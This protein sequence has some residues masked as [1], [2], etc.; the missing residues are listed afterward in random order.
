MI[1][2]LTTFLAAAALAVT[3]TLI[4]AR[5]ALAAPEDYHLSWFEAAEGDVTGTY[6]NV[7]G[8]I[9]ATDIGTDTLSEITN[10]SDLVIQPSCS[11]PLPPNATP[12]CFSAGD[13]SAEEWIPQGI[14]TTNDATGGSTSKILVSWYDGC[15]TGTQGTDWGRPN[16]GCQDGPNT[17]EAAD[18]GVRI[19]VYT[20][21]VG[22]RNVLLVEPFFNSSDNP[23]FH[24]THMH[25]GGIALYGNFLYVADT[26]YG[27]RVF[28][29]RKIFDLNEQLNPT[30]RPTN[31]SDKTKVG[32]HS[33]VWYSHG[34]RWVWPAVG[35]WRRDGTG[36]ATDCQGVGFPMKFSYLSV[37]RAARYLLA[38][39]YCPSD[40]SQPGRLAR[41]QLGS[42]AAT[43]PA[44]GIANGWAV[45][46]FNL[47]IDHIQ[48]GA[49][50]GGSTVYLNASDGASNYGKLWRY[51]VSG[52][53]LT[54]GA[55]VS[56]ARGCE[57]LSFDTWDQRI[58][59]VSEY[60]DRRAIY[61][62]RPSD[63]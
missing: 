7:I 51:Q 62:T 48:G 1:R 23:S 6:R 24:A 2:R 25:A 44:S 20:P 53:S 47:P 55:Y 46:A 58:Y 40:R 45:D 5:P 59:S 42:Q 26:R 37:D 30:N 52:T 41:W 34:Y 54:S 14:T 15:S 60:H 36:H 12:L 19:S 10:S 61:Y 50:V 33:N 38:G 63:F 28:D 13:N 32:R 21:H 35:E 43:S 11:D 29:T 18:K 8:Q 27:M 17:D 57:D 39:E 31:T 3:G 16:Q 22:Y 49:S 56:A 4:V 9:E